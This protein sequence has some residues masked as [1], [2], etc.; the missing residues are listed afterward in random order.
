MSILDTRRSVVLTVGVGLLF[1]IASAAPAQA[2]ESASVHGRALVKGQ[3]LA[4]AM[5][6]FHSAEGDPIMTKTRSGGTY[7]VTRVPPGEVRV[8]ILHEAVPPMYALPDTTPLA[9][10]IRPGRNAVNLMVRSALD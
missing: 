3:P 2:P 6:A 9:A 8:T 4:G 5:I 1:A 10:E 7:S